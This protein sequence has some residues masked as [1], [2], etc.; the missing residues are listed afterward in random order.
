V[1]ERAADIIKGELL[2]SDANAT[3]WIADDWE[4][5][6]RNMQGG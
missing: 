4:T 5:K 1:A 2:P 3:A 6:Q